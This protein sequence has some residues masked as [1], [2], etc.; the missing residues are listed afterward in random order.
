MLDGQAGTTCTTPCVLTP[1]AG[2]HTL[3][4][5]LPGFRTTTRSIKV[6][7]PMTDL[8]VFTI[9]QTSGILMLQTDPSGATVTVDN[10]RWPSATPTQLTLPAG[11]HKLSVEKGDLK[12][13]QEV[14]IRDGDLKSLSIPLTQP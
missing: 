2:D 5:S 11:K 9:T 7:D 13:T 10:Q 3:T 1:P 14:E 8:P 4:L 6:T 12:T